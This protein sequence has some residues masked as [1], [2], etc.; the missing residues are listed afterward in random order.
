MQYAALIFTG[1]L[2]LT[3]ASTATAQAMAIN[4]AARW[5]TV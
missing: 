3:M 2:M 4:R 5:A 1:N